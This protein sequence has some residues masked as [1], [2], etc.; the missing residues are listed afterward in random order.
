MAAKERKNRK[1]RG[2]QF[3]DRSLQL[4]LLRT[5]GSLAAKRSSQAREPVGNCNAA[6]TTAL[7]SLRSSRLCGLSGQQAFASHLGVFAPLR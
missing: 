4:I 7:Q 6:K 3:H 2:D 1:K 5:L